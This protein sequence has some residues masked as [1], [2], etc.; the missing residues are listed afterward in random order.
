MAGASSPAVW[1]KAT[2]ASD[3][4][5]DRTSAGEQPVAIRL[6]MSSRCL[7]GPRNPTLRLRRRCRRRRCARRGV[8]VAG[9]K[10]AQES[11]K[12]AGGHYLFGNALK[13]G[14]GGSQ[15]CGDDLERA[16]IG[17]IGHLGRVFLAE[18]VEPDRVLGQRIGDSATQ[19]IRTLGISEGRKVAPALTVFPFNL[20]A[21][22][23]PAMRCP[24]NIGFM[25]P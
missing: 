14:T 5:D 23:L 3:P 9:A 25:C 19:D 17:S 24:Q 12:R 13:L 16:P 2:G 15:R 21:C 1:C 11:V 22:L 4:A 18:A 6:V 20:L 10:I 7:L 8:R